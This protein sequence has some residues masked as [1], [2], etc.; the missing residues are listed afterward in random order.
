VK[1]DLAVAGTDAFMV[2]GTTRHATHYILKVRIGGVA[3]LVAP[4]LGKQ[5]PDSQVWVPEGEA[6]AFVRSETPLFPGGPMMRTELV[7]PVW[8]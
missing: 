2:A 5:P 8:R 4:L 1:V 7:S 6:P 3:G